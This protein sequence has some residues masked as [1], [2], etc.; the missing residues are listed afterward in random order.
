M[1]SPQKTVLVRHDRHSAIRATFLPLEGGG[2]ILQ[3]AVGHNGYQADVSHLIGARFPEFAA[4]KLALLAS[5]K[6]AVGDTLDRV[7]LS[8]A[9]YRSWINMVRSK[10]IALQRAGYDC[11]QIPDEQARP[12]K[13]GGLLIWVNIPGQERL[14]MLIPKDQWSWRQGQ[15]EH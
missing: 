15:G 5:M 1:T 7:L 10:A 9:A 6:A 13:E 14:S 4:L 3:K 11:S 2:L 8:E 12:T